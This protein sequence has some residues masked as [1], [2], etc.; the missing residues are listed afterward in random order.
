MDGAREHM[1]GYLSVFQVFT[2]LLAE[3]FRPR[4]DARLQLLAYQVKM[5]R[6]RIDDER[7]YTKPEERAELMRLGELLDHDIA[8]A[9]LVVKPNTYKSWLKPKEE[10]QRKPGRPRTAEATVNLVLQFASDNLAWGYK[11]LHGELKK[12]GNEAPRGK[13]TR[14]QVVFNFVCTTQASGN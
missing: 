4:Y 5:L 9:M 3:K 8:D 7:I 2:M 13:P 10:K 11:K 14:Y 6:N 12:L 1:S